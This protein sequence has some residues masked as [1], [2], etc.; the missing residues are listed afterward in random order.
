[1]NE[2]NKNKKNLNFI[3]IKNLFISTYFISI[4]N[5]IYIYIKLKI[6]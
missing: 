1:M 6:Q 3:Q 5:H 4:K 2:V